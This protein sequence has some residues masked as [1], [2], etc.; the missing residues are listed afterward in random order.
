MSCDKVLHFITVNKTPQHLNHYC[1]F[2]HGVHLNR[3]MNGGNIERRIQIEKEGAREGEN[4]RWEK[5]LAL[6]VYSHVTS[7]S[8]FVVSCTFDVFTVACEQNHETAFN[9]F[10]NGEKNS[11]F[12]GTC[13]LTLTVLNI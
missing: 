7:K 3:S 11:D 8:P 2:L 10:L 12:D 5:S 13:E 4:M 6:R 1:V 9:P